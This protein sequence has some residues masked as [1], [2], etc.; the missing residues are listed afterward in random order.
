MMGQAIES[1]TRDEGLA[2]PESQKDGR[3]DPGELLVETSRVVLHKLRTDGVEVID[4]HEHPLVEFLFVARNHRDPLVGVQPR[5]LRV[6]LEVTVEAR[7]DSAG[8]GI[9]ALEVEKIPHALLITLPLGLHQS[10]AIPHFVPALQ[11]VGVG[12]VEERQLLV[13]HHDIL[14]VLLEPCRPFEDETL[15]RFGIAQGV[16]E[17]GLPSQGMTEVPGLLHPEFSDDELVKS[18]PD[19]IQGAGH[20]LVEVA[21][22]RGAP[23][24]HVRCDHPEAVLDRVL[25]QEAVVRPEGP[26]AMHDHEHR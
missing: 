16:A 23:L 7:A 19:V 11:V 25:D 14:G 22:A 21:R 24:R 26:L 15:H 1:G 6:A 17:H 2:S 5:V 20:R 12:L 18:V 3:L 4:E 13:S 10:G 9:A 8:F